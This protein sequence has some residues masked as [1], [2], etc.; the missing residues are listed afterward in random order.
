[1]KTIKQQQ[2][3]NFNAITFKDAIIML[4]LMNELVN[5]IN[6]NHVANFYNNLPEDEKTK[7]RHVWRKTDI[8]LSEQ[9]METIFNLLNELGFES[10][11]EFKEPIINDLEKK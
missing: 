4:P 6:Q 5:A 7:Y 1:M 8:R 10:S 11:N 3:I 2:E 9:E